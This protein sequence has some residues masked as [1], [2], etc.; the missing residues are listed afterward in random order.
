MQ[1]YMFLDMDVP[2][3]DVHAFFLGAKYLWLHPM[4]EYQVFI[5]E[6]PEKSTMTA[7]I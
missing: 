6:Y 2:S 4:K 1:I 7:L 3:L 5:L